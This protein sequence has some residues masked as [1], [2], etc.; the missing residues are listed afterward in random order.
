MIGIFS[1]RGI[2]DTARVHAQIDVDFRNHVHEFN[3]GYNLN[4]LA[5]FM[6]IA[7]H[8]NQD[9][10]AWPSRELLKKETGLSTDDAISNAIKHLREMDIEG[11]PVL[12]HYRLRDKK[13][14]R[15]DRSLYLIFPSL[16]HGEPPRELT[17]ECKVFIVKND[18]PQTIEPPPA[19]PG[20]A[21]PGVARLGYKKNHVE[22]EPSLSISP[23]AREKSIDEEN[24]ES[25]REFESFRFGE[26]YQEKF[27]EIDTP[28]QS[29]DNPW[30]LWGSGNIKPRSG[31]EARHLQ[32]IGWLIEQ[33][34]G[35]YPADGKWKSWNK[36]LAQMFQVAK[37]DFDTIGRG[38]DLAMD[39]EPKYRPST[40]HGFA[41]AI[42]QVMTDS[43]EET[44]KERRERIRQQMES[45]PQLQAIRKAKKM[46]QQ[47]GS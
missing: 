6:C 32:R 41:N 13:S 12:A 3:S 46:R 17:E 37:G 25:R 7:L 27:G 11:V 22:E 26:A 24:T 44:G 29:S 4:A 43:K 40:P 8:A 16:P 1:G 5:V 19:E 36:A 23:T 30:L 18:E 33:K 9:G 2:A 31:I 39:R 28:Q 15:W 21:Q 45:D 20:V 35:W 10:W 47:N 14:Q 38:I 42:R 34:T